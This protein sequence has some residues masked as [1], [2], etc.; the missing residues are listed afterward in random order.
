M[1]PATGL[2]GGSDPPVTPVSRIMDSFHRFRDTH[3]LVSP[4]RMTTPSPSVSER[5]ATTSLNMN[6]P[7]LNN[8]I[9]TSNIVDNECT[10]DIDDVIPAPR[11]IEPDGSKLE[12]L[13][14]SNNKNNK[15]TLSSVP[16]TDEDLDSAKKQNQVPPSNHEI[17]MVLS[18]DLFGGESPSKMRN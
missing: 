10:D 12:D 5:I 15:I 9:M 3:N 11:Q 8:V 13:S 18:Q 4:Q 17:Q 16:N 1:A 6:P 2:E 7:P 14:L